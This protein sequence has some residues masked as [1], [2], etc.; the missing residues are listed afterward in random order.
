MR[1]E[2]G[3]EVLDAG[4]ELLCMLHKCLGV[5]DNGLELLCMLDKVL[6]LHS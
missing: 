4:L 6:K 1:V 3:M 2:Q 5:L